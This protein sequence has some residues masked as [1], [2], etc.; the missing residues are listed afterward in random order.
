MKILRQLTI[1]NTKVQIYIIG[2]IF[3]LFFFINLHQISTQHWS[4]HMDQDV[5]IL[6][7]SLLISSG[8]EQQARDH[9]A[10]ST[11]FI[12]GGVFKFLSFFQEKYSSN[13]DIILNSQNINKT[14]QFY[15]ITARITNYF[16]NI[17]LIF[18]FYKLLNLL[19]IDKKINF[20][21]C[22]IFIFSQWYSMSF[23]V[24]RSEILSLLFFTISMIFILS[25]QRDIILNYFIGGIFFGLA[26]LTKI[27]I[28][29]FIAYPF[30]LIP[31][32]FLDHLNYHQNFF[33][34]KLLNNYLLCSFVAG[35]I[36]YIIFQI[37]IQEYPRFEKNKFLDLF[38]FLFSFFIILF[39]YFMFNKYNFD[40]FKKNIIL[41]SS[42]LNGY[43]FLMFIIIFLDLTNLLQVNDYIY[44]R[45]TNPIHYLTE[46]KST[47]AEGTINLNFLASSF[48]KI[49]TSYIYSLLELLT[50][51]FI[52]FLNIKKN[53]NK[54]KSYLIY[55][56]ILSLI[57]FMNS[58]ISSYR[59][60]LYYH[61]Y[62]TFCYLII[63]AVCINDLNER[64]SKYFLYIVFIF[65]TYN[66]LYTYSS[67][68]TGGPNNYIK[69]FNR[70][71]YMTE[72]CNQ[73][74]LKNFKKNSQINIAYL[75][76]WHNKFDDN[77]I[78]KICKEL[79]N[80]S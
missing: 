15:F 22:L 49:F 44:L 28:L 18:V 56:I 39:Y 6:Y 60:A 50:L 46:F 63:L 1:N 79:E 77:V 10:F 31:I 17:F 29:F 66:G 42:I 57:F 16:I 25:K 62:Y 58:A 2:L 35:I 21:I 69:T 34:K 9:P 55:I 30:L 43:I 67:Y 7:N 71:I 61:S 37:F 64:Y 5:Y 38:F 68:D 36:L 76:Y 48:Y 23:F 72:A 14:L 40:Y 20:F 12:H 8:Y 26:M 53:I 3:V 13:I 24:L 47:F 27:Q 52:I 74:D 41:L 73:L 51:V 59:E 11:F 80:E 32:F 54:S 19:N 33:K 75:K 65:F 70:D 4:G 45:I 78:N